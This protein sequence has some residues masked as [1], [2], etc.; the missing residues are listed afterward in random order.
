MRTVR[1]TVREPR[2]WPRFLPLHRGQTGARRLPLRCRLPFP[3]HRQ[4]LPN[5]FTYS[6]P[7]HAAAIAKAIRMWTAITGQSL[8]GRGQ[9]SMPSAKPCLYPASKPSAWPSSKPFA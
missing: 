6:E 8:C 5:G 7:S 1:W 3:P 9:A 4:H 2:R